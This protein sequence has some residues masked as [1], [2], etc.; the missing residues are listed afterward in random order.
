MRPTAARPRRRRRPA[1]PSPTRAR[2]RARGC[3]TKARP[4]RTPLGRGARRARCSSSS[5]RRSI[6]ATRIPR[7][8]AARRHAARR[9]PRR[10]TRGKRPSLQCFAEG[11]SIRSCLERSIP[12]GLVPGHH[13][14]LRGGAHLPRSPKE[15]AA[16]TARG[17]PER[18]RPL[19]R[20]MSTSVVRF[21]PRSCAARFLLPLVRASA[22]RMRFVS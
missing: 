6:S 15:F 1:L 5:S 19:R 4:H 17:R 16:A 7:D 18:Q 22:C 21:K 8:P 9:E 13:G 3:P 20:T 10:P 11:C 12:A 2:V 14:A